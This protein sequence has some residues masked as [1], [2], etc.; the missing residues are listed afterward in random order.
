VIPI[1]DLLVDVFGYRFACALLTANGIRFVHGVSKYDVA[2]L[3]VDN[4]Y[5]GSCWE[6]RNNMFAQPALSESETPVSS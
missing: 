2:S 1:L 5:T 4:L 3:Q 6:P